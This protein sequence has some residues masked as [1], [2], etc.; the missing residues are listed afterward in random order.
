MTPSFPA[1]AFWQARVRRCHPGHFA[2]ALADPPGLD[3]TWIANHAETRLLG[4]D[5]NAIAG[6]AGRACD[7]CAGC[8]TARSRSRCRASGSSAACRP[9]P[10][11]RCRSPA[12]RDRRGAARRSEPDRSPS[13]CRAGH[14]RRQH[15]NLAGARSAIAAHRGSQRAVADHRHVEGDDG[16]EWYRADL[17]EGVTNSPIAFGYLH[18]SLCASPLPLCDAQSDRG[19]RPRHTSK[20]TCASRRCWCLGG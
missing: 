4:A 14:S 3:A 10:S 1:A 11:A 13:G 20:L 6:P 19:E 17:L 2:P 18:H 7:C 5:G 8:P 15:P 16:Q 9:T 12:R